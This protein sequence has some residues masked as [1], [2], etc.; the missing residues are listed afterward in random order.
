[1][2][3]HIHIYMYIYI[4]I[5]LYIYLY[6]TTCP[7]HH[8]WHL[9][10][11]MHTSVAH[12]SATLTCLATIL[13]TFLPGCHTH[14]SKICPSGPTEPLHPAGSHAGLSQ[15]LDSLRAAS[16]RVLLLVAPSPC[17]TESTGCRLWRPGHRWLS[18]VSV[19]VVGLDCVSSK[20][21]AIKQYRFVFSSMT[22]VHKV[23]RPWTFCIEFSCS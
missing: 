1:M 9:G 23:A 4:Y 7:R 12:C 5:H 6:A 21:H 8:A 19:P 20:Q 17:Q 11:C 13:L 10:T 2:I 3:P 22:A 15:F 16:R 14:S 18:Q